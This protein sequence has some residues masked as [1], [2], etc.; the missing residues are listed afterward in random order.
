MPHKSRN[1]ENPLSQIAT[2]AM[3]LLAAVLWTLL[4]LFSLWT[5]REQLNRTAMEL[6]RIDAIANLKKDMAIRNWA[7][8]V[9]GVFINENLAPNVDALSEQ[10]R[11]QGLRMTGESLKL[12]SLTPIHI[13]M[14][15]QEVSN[16]EYGSKERL[17]SLQL[18]NRDNAPDE[19]ET[20]ALKTLQKGSEMV[21]ESMPKKKGHGLMRVM[22]PMRMEEEC[23]ECH[24]ETLVPVGGL[25]GAASVSVDLN[26]YWSAQEPAWRTIQY[27][28]TGIW[29]AGLTLLYAYWSFLRR[30]AAEHARQEE[31]RRENEAAFSA[32][33]EGAMITDAAGDILWVNDAFCHIHGYTRDEVIG[34]N[35]RMLKSGRHDGDFYHRLWD[36]LSHQGRWRGEVWNRRKNGEVFP[37]ELSIQALRDDHGETVR[38]ISIFSDITERKRQ[39]EALQQNQQRLEES[40]TRLRELAAFLETVRE[41]ERTRI[42]RELHDELGQALTALRFDLGWLRGRATPLGAPAAERVAAALGVVEQSIVSLRRISEDLR[43]AMLDSLGLAAA[44]EHHVTQ[45]TQRNGIP[46]RLHMNREEFELDSNL[47][48]AVFRIVQEALTNIAR[49]AEAGEVRIDI[50]QTDDAGGGIRLVVEDDGRGFDVASRTTRFGLLGMRERITMLGGT[51]DIDS[52]PE[53]GTRIAAWLPLQK[54]SCA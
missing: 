47:A 43:P 24:R 7:S 53:H 6:A 20:A 33:A 36:E 3:L 1:R 2:P 35:P 31:K 11:L 39:E 22:I 38:Y 44:V 15:I 51:L 17:T 18:L 49:H 45:F 16:R 48:T 19:W 29:L 12:I 27:W 41:E 46:C 10:E 13:L 34:R 4:V 54:E 32:M 5:Q 26:T 52:R 37:K 30:R 25:R 9:G 14:G 8:K 23:L 21:A 40:E 50:E 42:A 28:H